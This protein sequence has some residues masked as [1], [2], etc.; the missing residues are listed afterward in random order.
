MRTHWASEFRFLLVAHKQTRNETKYWAKFSQVF[1]AFC[2]KNVWK[3]EW[4]IVSLGGA[5]W[6]AIKLH[7]K[8]RELNAL[9]IVKRHF[10]SRLLYE[11]GHGS[12][13]SRVYWLLDIYAELAFTAI[14]FLCGT[15]FFIN[16]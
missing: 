7:L 1:S 12:R 6:A 11:K 16:T 14:V 4:A 5:P 15:V 2:G 9:F 10:Y 13:S 3:Q 8:S